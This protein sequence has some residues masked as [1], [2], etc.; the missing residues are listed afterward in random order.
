MKWYKFVEFVNKHYWKLFVILILGLVT[1]SGLAYASLQPK[2]ITEVQKEPKTLYKYESSYSI[3][4]EVLK[5]NSIWRKGKVLENRPVYFKKITPNVKIDFEYSIIPKSTMK[6]TYSTELVFSSVKDGDTYWQKQA[7]L[8]EEQFQ[9]EEG[10]L[11]DSI[12]LNINDLERKLE[13][14]QKGIDFYRGDKKVKV[15]T[16]LNF[17]T[18]VS[19]KSI[20][21]SEKFVLPINLQG[22]S[23]KIPQKNFKGKEDKEVE[24]KENKK[25]EPSLKDKILGSAPPLV[26]FFLL[27]AFSFI[28]LKIDV[29]SDEKLQKLEI[30]KDHEEY[31]E[32]ISAGKI[33]DNL[34][35]RKIEINTLEDLVKIAI[36]TEE[37]VIHDKEASIYFTIH[38]GT[39]YYFDPAKF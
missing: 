15:I 28:K 17:D 25:V 29:P 18:K 19:G 32:M 7:I 21:G 6:G 20:T 9:V 39:F 35:T 4:T 10:I 13:D 24:V 5:E 36:D 2:T 8:E 34:D 14:I 26:L 11:T 1:T 12:E 30:K 3:S 38:D 23:F 16:R 33:P 37:R 22:S 31:S 27:A